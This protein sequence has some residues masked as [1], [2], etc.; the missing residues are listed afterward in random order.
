MT[1]HKTDEEMIRK[2][3]NT[4]R[5][6]VET[7]H[8]AWVLLIGTAVW[9]VYGYRSMPQRKDPD[10]PV[11]V[12]VALTPWPGA[13]AER[14]EQLVTKKV[15]TRIGENSNVIEIKSISRTGLSVVY[16]E[17]DQALKETGEQLDD[18]KLKLDSIRDLPDGAGPIHFIKD[19]GDTAA[20]MLTVAS[21]KATEVEV[22]LRAR[23]IRSAIEKKRTAAKPGSRVTVVACFP[24]SID[25]RIIRRA[26]DA[27]LDWNREKRFAMDARIIE[28]SGFQGVDFATRFDDGRLKE[29]IEEFIRESLKASDFHPDAWYFALVRD[30]ADTQA[31]L[32]EVAGDK[33][34]YRE[35][36]DFTDRIEKMV[37]TVPQVSKVTRSGIL[38]EHVFLFYSQ[39]RLASYGIVSGQLPN[40]LR[41]RNITIPGGVL[42]V[43]GK[44]LSIDP[45]GEFSS[46]KEIGDVLTLASATGAPMY[47]RDLVEI[48]RGIRA[49][50]AF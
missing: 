15:E 4:A 9:G 47:L 13:T 11:R 34:S 6:F 22:S 20:L 16:L 17:L 50:P 45:S 3:R 46:E 27:A 28:G 41:A 38:P 32:A 49:R 23:S 2:T 14:V 18:I 33:Y 40:I 37:K 39:E 42:E 35:L 5:F 48:C 12:A 21:P 43:G 10:I 30:P 8:I 7:R 31:R 26:I 29:L 1:Q 44:N 19:F 24:L 25:P 36:D